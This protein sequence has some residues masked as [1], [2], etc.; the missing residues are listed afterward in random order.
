MTFLVR[1]CSNGTA[2]CSMCI[3]YVGILLDLMSAGYFKPVVSDVATFV[4][5][6]VALTNGGGSSSNNNNNGGGGSSGQPSGYGPSS[7]N[8]GGSGDYNPNPCGPI[9][10]YQLMN[11][12]GPYI[13]PLTF[14]PNSSATPT[15]TGTYMPGSGARGRISAPKCCPCFQRLVRAYCKMR[16]QLAVPS[17]TPARF[18]VTLSLCKQPN[19]T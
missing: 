4:V 19:Q 10:G 2:D 15:P 18:Q 11:N 14:A 7:S 1:A 8:N 12:S 9:G 6:V 17:P 3:A 16:L 5:E 13:P